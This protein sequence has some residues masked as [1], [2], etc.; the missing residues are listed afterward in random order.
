M[1]ISLERIET[2]LR[3]KPVNYV[4]SALA[5][6]LGCVI[7]KENINL[8]ASFLKKEIE[9]SQISIDKI[10][11]YIEENKDKIVFFGVNL[12]KNNPPE[13]LSMGVAITYAIY[14]IYLETKKNREL[15]DYLKRK[16]IPKAE[17]FLNQIKIIKIN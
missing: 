11:K 16:R 12:L 2:I 6:Q 14:L 7:Y 3:S 9:A 1:K 15:L 10:E 13:K 5:K 4:E 8:L 17:K